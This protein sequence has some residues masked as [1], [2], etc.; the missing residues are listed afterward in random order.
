MLGYAK[1]YRAELSLVHQL[2]DAGWMAI[3]TPKSGRLNL[4]SPDVIAAKDGRLLVIECKSRKAGFKVE[5][6]QLLQLREWEEKAKATA[7]VGW[8]ISHKGWRFLRLKDVIDNNG[9]IG[10]KIIEKVSIAFEEI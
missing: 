10:K 5:E 7:Y 4:A 3:R 6:T 2:S 9:N 1:G 8:K